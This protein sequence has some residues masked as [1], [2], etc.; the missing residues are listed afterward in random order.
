MTKVNAN[1]EFS[2]IILVDEKEKPVNKEYMGRKFQLIT[3]KTLY[4]EKDR[5]L[6]RMLG[7]LAIIATLGLALISKHIRNL[8]TKSIKSIRVEK[9][10]VQDLDSS[11]T[12]TGSELKYKIKEDQ[13][14]IEEKGES[15]KKT[16]VIR[17]LPLPPEGVI[18]NGYGEYLVYRNDAEGNKVAVTEKEYETIFE[19]VEAARILKGDEIP[20]DRH[21]YLEGKIQEK[22]GNEVRI[23]FIPRTLY[24]QIF[25]H[26]CVQEEIN[27]KNCL[28]ANETG[29]SMGLQRTSPENQTRAVYGMKVTPE[30]RKRYIKTGLEG[31]FWQLCIYDDQDYTDRFKNRNEDDYRSAHLI[32]V[33]SRLNE[34]ALGKFKGKRDGFTF[35]E[36]LEAQKAETSFFKSF[37]DPTSENYPKSKIPYSTFISITQRFRDET[38]PI[39]NHDMHPLGIRNERDEQIL[40]KAIQLECSAEAVNHLVLYR[41]AKFSDDEVTKLHS[42]EVI[43]NSLSYGTSL[44]AGVLYD[45]GATAIQYMRQGYVDAQSYLVPLKYQFA[46]QTPFH[47]FIA[48]PL[49]SLGSH[50][51][52]FHAR[53]KIWSLPDE[54]RVA[55]F[56]SYVASFDSIK[57]CCKTRE[58]KEKVEKSFSEYKSKAYILAPK[59][60]PIAPL[61]SVS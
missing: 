33:A 47:A 35:A 31:A 28:N 34:V 17:P 52:I 46:G 56:L 2:T 49:I 5:T 1:K 6:R 25:L 57:D 40:Q 59:V 11:L 8:L 32:K 15:K 39:R 16:S 37:K 3:H 54:Q 45:G 29:I 21:S 18:K 58:T 9:L 26:E 42:N 19:V 43:A 36:I 27:K 38:H 60:S 53:T 23:S 48:H 4:S 44:Y 55:G 10:P 7:V 12:K 61:Q 13:P 14:L 50:G 22:L 30:D 20:S 41:G 51:E 24:E